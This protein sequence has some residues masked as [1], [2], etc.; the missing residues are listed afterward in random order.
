MKYLVLGSISA[1]HSVWTLN[2]VCLLESFAR[3]KKVL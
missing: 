2:I 3:A 1:L